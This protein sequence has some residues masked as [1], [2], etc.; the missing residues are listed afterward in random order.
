MF[1][2]CYANCNRITK[3][4]YDIS[5]CLI[6]TKVLFVFYNTSALTIFASQIIIEIFVFQGGQFIKQERFPPPGVA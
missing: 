5:N 2:V 3:H 6:V 1:I 4:I